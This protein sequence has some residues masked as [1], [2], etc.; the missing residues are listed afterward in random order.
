MD[1]PGLMRLALGRMGLSPGVF[2][3]LTPVEFLT[4]LGLEA[5]PFPL[6]RDELER[7]ERAF[8][9]ASAPRGETDEGGPHGS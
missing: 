9:D 7:L 5:G 2:W 4:M 8:P 6:T 1:W 3:S